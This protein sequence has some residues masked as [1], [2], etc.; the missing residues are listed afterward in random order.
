VTTLA[1][2]PSTAFLA[3]CQ[4][5]PGSS[6]RF[7]QAT[8]MIPFGGPTGVAV[9]SLG[10]VYVTD[11]GNHVIRRI[12]QNL[13]PTDPNFVT[14]LAGSPTSPAYDQAAITQYFT[15]GTLPPLNG[16]ADGTGSAAQ[17]YFPG[18]VAVDATGKLYVADTLNHLI[19]VSCQCDPAKVKIGLYA[20][21][22]IE[23]KIGCQY[24]IDYTTFLNPNPSLTI[25]TTLT[26]IT[27]SSSSFLYVDTTVVSGNRFYRV[28]PL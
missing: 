27:L 6:A 2:D 26:T 24:R 12:N 8:A 13:L 22:T 28:V 7:S 15:S 10:N 18:G 5:G 14:T 19:R 16:S 20:G 3:G 11:A 4:D 23:G 9:D 17:F 1:G 25:W 21:L